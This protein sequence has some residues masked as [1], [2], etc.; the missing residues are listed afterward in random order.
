MTSTAAIREKIGGE[1]QLLRD[2]KTAPKKLQ[3]QI[4]LQFARSLFEIFGGRFSKEL[5]A[6]LSDPSVFNQVHRAF[7]EIQDRLKAGMAGYADLDCPATAKLIDGY[8][9]ESQNDT[10]VFEDLKE[11]SYWIH[12]FPQKVLM[13][14]PS[15]EL[16]ILAK[17]E[18]VRY[19]AFHQL[20]NRLKAEERGLEKKEEDRV[21]PDPLPLEEELPMTKLYFGGGV[22]VYEGEVVYFS[23]MVTMWGNLNPT[24]EQRVK[25]LLGQLTM[26]NWAQA[27]TKQVEAFL[28]LRSPQHSFGR[29]LILCSI[30][31]VE[32]Q[33]RTVFSPSVAAALE[34]KFGV[35]ENRS[36]LCYFTRKISRFYEWDISAFQ[37]LSTPL[38][39]SFQLFLF[40]TRNFDL[41]AEV[42]NT[43]LM[44]LL[45]MDSNWKEKQLLSFSQRKWKGSSID[46]IEMDAFH[47]AWKGLE[48]IV[49]CVAK[50]QVSFSAPA[51]ED[52]D[53]FKRQ[54]CSNLLFFLWA[55]PERKAFVDSISTFST[56]PR[57]SMT[58]GTVLAFCTTN[59]NKYGGSSATSLCEGYAQVAK[60]FQSRGVEEEGIEHV[61]FDPPLQ[62]LPIMFPALERA[63]QFTVRFVNAMQQYTDFPRKKKFYLMLRQFIFHPNLLMFDLLQD[64]R[65]F[66]ANLSNALLWVALSKSH[67]GFDPEPIPTGSSRDHA[68]ELTTE[69]Q[70]AYQLTDEHIFLIYL[71]TMRLVIRKEEGVVREISAFVR[72]L[73]SFCP[74]IE[75]EVF[76]F[77]FHY[78]PGVNAASLSMFQQEREAWVRNEAQLDRFVID[79][80]FYLNIEEQAFEF[81]HSLSAECKDSEIAE[82]F[83]KTLQASLL[84]AFFPPL[85]PLTDYF[86]IKRITAEGAQW[87]E[88][89][90]KTH[91]GQL[92]FVLGEGNIGIYFNWSIQKGYPVLFMSFF[93]RKEGEAYSAFIPLEVPA[94]EIETDPRR[95]A[96]YG[97][98]VNLASQVLR[99]KADGDV[100]DG[101]P[102]T[103]D[104]WIRVFLGVKEAID[105]YAEEFAN[106]TLTPGDLDKIWDFLKRVKCSYRNL[107]HSRRSL[108][109]DDPNVVASQGHIFTSHPRGALLPPSLFE[110]Q[111]HKEWYIPDGSDPC[112]ASCQDLFN[113][114]TTKPEPLQLSLNMP[115]GTYPTFYHAQ[116]AAQVTGPIEKRTHR[117][118]VAPPIE[119]EEGMFVTLSVNEVRVPLRYPPEALENRDLFRQYFDR[120]NLF[121]K[122][123]V[124]NS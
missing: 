108:L 94:A 65:Y 4:A 35:E 6:Q 124:Y 110:D 123:A 63:E 41:S 36:D 29:F 67:R 13:E 57:F 15:P 88:P 75:K 114:P 117:N 18:R 62:I 81:A 27:D 19:R 105:G 22:I 26:R 33:L 9:E 55:H 30:H 104:S 51:P 11:R 52:G 85:K 24:N 37:R 64:A 14:H 119:L 121:L 7:H 95:K 112:V 49:S 115:D 80:K 106:G 5:R 118:E 101:A 17:I 56:L 122:S 25:Q 53:L 40:F 3:P 109:S 2:Q 68:Q 73:V 116:T 72:Q 93:N 48:K 83:N 70:Q 107:F 10:L 97:L 74:A 34:Q 42:H 92:K 84:S 54:E 91:V 23:E 82:A 66:R 32:K 59:Q 28:N 96:F 46:P 44:I 61:F 60:A 100:P 8:R 43:L 76:F 16:K 69:I 20:L 71:E 86:R 39:R 21:Q 103:P 120:H 79:Q 77:L 45:H 78:H 31:V 58:L 87:G 89:S 102:E 38:L 111:P 50:K 99:E 98:L 90:W 47:T 113:H 1:L 12:P